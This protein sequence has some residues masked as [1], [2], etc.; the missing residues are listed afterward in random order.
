[1]EINPEIIS[2]LKEHR[3]NKD[4]GLLFLLG[5]YFKLD[6]DR[7][8][9]ENLIKIMN[10]TK[11]VERDYAS[12]ANLKWN[13]SLFSGQDTNWDWVATKYNEMWNINRARK[14]NSSDV[15][16]RMQEWFKKYPQYRKQDV[17]AATTAYFK[18]VKDVQYLKSSAKFIF[19]GIGA[20]KISHLLTWCEKTVGQK[21]GSQM[22]GTIIR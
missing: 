16:K 3:I 4:E 6:V 19:E 1:M 15:T 21:E 11:I 7:I 9:S 14:D 13:V 18:S 8:C 22:K 12:K 20:A 10:L 2:I 17:Q 5:V